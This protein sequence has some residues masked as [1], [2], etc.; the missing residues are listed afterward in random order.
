MYKIIVSSLIV[1]MAVS[2][3]AQNIEII[4]QPFSVDVGNKSFHLSSKTIIIHD[5]E[6]EENAR[7]L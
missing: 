5:S 6:N 4:P 2:I 7:Y 1:L 3:N